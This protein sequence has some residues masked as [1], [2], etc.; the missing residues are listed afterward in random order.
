M[1]FILVWSGVDLE[2]QAWT[3]SFVQVVLDPVHRIRI[4]FF[5]SPYFGCQ[6]LRIFGVGF[7]KPLGFK[8]GL[9][10]VKVLRLL[11]W[12]N[13]GAYFDSLVWINRG[14]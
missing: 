12:R 4:L 3:V 1:Y 2:R 5:N 13:L 11:G 10:R 14:L 9:F 7:G 6:V 8:I